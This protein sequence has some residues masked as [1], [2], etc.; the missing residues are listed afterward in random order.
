[1]AHENTPLVDGDL[2]LRRPV[3][4]DVAARIE[5]GNDAEIQ[6]MYGHVDGDGYVSVA[7]AEKW[8]SFHQKRAHSW[9]IDIDKTLSGVIF[10]HSLDQ[11]DRRAMLAM[12]LLRRADLGKGFGSRALRLLL[13]HAF[14]AMNLHRVSLRVLAY[15]LRAIAAYKKAGFVHEG[16][17]R[18]SARVGDTWHDDVMMGLLAHEWR[19]AA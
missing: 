15:N 3:A 14:G 8:V 12:G 5:A 10:L 16:R 11:T 7:Q 4:Q 19:A 1:M 17:E 18:Q 2:I 6:R 13:G 9:F